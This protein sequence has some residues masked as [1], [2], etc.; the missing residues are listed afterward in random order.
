MKSWRKVL[1][2]LLALALVVGMTA[3]SGG[4]ESS[5]ST[6]ESS[7]SETSEPADESSEPADES[8][9]SEEAE[10]PATDDTTTGSYPR[11]ESLY[12]GGQQWATPVSNNPMAA[13]ANYAAMANGDTGARELVWETLYMYNIS[14]SKDYPLLADGDWVWADDNSTVTVK[15]KA[16]AHWSDGSDLTAADVEASWDAY[17]NYDTNLGIAYEP[18]ITDI[19]AVDDDTV[20]FQVNTGDGMNLMKVEELI[21]KMYIMQKAYLE[22]LDAANGSDAT[23]MK[24]EA[25][26]DAPST[27][28]YHPLEQNDQKWVIQRDDNYWG[29]DE[30]MWGKLP[31]PKY[32]I[33]NIYSSNDVGAQA[34]MNGEI[35]INQMYTANI[36]TMWEDEGLPISTYMEE[37]PYNGP[38]TI[39]TVVYNVQK[40]GLDQTALRKAIAMAVDYDQII[41]SAMTGQSPTFKEY[42]RT[43]F[44]WS[45][46][47]QAMILDKEALAPLQ[48]TGNDVE[49]AIA[50]LDEAGIVDS[51]GDG[52]R[53]WN[54]AELSFKVECPTG[55]SDYEAALTIVQEAGKDLGIAIETYFPEAAQYNDDLQAGNFDITLT[56]YGGT[57]YGAAYF[58]MYGF[59]GEFPEVMTTN[60]GRWY[61]EEA[62]ALI[63]ELANCLDETRQLE[64]Y[65][66]LNEI[67]LTEVPSFGVMYRPFQ[68]MACNE[69]VWTNF[70]NENDGSDPKIPPMMCS[71][72]YGV[73]ALYNLELV[74]G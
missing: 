9:S 20:E 27:A 3:C 45:D 55:W 10:E 49:G 58:Y 68:F 37:P 62:D 54:G 61:N 19:V 56:S 42:P 36:Q 72:G 51:N 2:L 43:L 41:A 21:R 16:A 5:T 11:E 53:E 17:V 65:Q 59:G 15:L 38:G 7:T 29:Q 12:Q 33:H 60:Q 71:D 52:N 23:A 24:N 34:F 26:W 73:A 18:Y 48:W 6:P 64:I 4:G 32:I 1:A 13:N 44:N 47:Q 57:T 8:E 31:V 22:E 69:S 67:Y 50:L 66:R 74:N 28:P 40:P 70:P 25:M 35:D 46:A 39:P 63:E 30:S 14:D